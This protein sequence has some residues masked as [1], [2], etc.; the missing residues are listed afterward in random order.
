[1]CGHGGACHVQ[2]LVL[3]KERVISRIKRQISGRHTDINVMLC[4]FDEFQVCM[5]SVGYRATN[6]KPT[7]IVDTVFLQNSMTPVG[8]ATTDLDFAGRQGFLQGWI[9]VGLRS[10]AVASLE[11]LTESAAFALPL[12]KIRMA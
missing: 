4:L 9:I 10:P 8:C 1:M 11:A 2:E 5:S 3:Y 12:F 6:K 7:S